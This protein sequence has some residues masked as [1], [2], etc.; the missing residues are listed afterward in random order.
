MIGAQDYK[1]N[2][3]IVGAGPSGIYCALQLIEEFKKIGQKAYSI[4]SFLTP[5]KHCQ[6]FFLP[7]T[8]DAT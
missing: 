2:I 3:A 7:E 8:A 6:P 1:P 5:K 4:N